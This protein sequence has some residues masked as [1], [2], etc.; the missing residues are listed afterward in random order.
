M[1]SNDRVQ[2]NQNLGTTKMESIADIHCSLGGE[3]KKKKKEYR[4]Q[5][6]YS[7]RLRKTML[8]GSSVFSVMPAQAVNHFSLF[9]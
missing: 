4:A 8:N 3:A 1:M 7:I 6:D 5:R 9:P 2:R